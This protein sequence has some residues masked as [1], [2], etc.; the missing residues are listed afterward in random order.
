MALNVGE[1]DTILAACDSNGVQFMDCTI[2]MHHPRT[3][4]LKQ[5][6]SEEQRFGQLKSVLPSLCDNN[7]IQNEDEFYKNSLGF[8]KKSN[9]LMHLFL[10]TTNSVS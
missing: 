10:N 4:K 5:L 9:Q 3:A 7:N 2:W 1:L 8:K 6:L